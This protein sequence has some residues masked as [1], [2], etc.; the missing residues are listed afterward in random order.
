[1][2]F[3]DYQTQA[4][5]TDLYDGTYNSIAH[6]SFMEKALGLVGESGEFADKLKKVLRDKDG[7]LDEAD[8]LEILKELGDVLWYVSSLAHY[9]DIPL[10]KL[11]QNN[12][13]KVLSRRARG[14]TMGSG[15]NR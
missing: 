11:A 13:D 5:T 7:V 12:L 1:M 9:L 14:V 4:I 15:D 10:S 2:K 6:P 8:R 3:D